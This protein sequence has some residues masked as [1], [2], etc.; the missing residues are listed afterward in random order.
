MKKKLGIALGSGSA[1]GWSHIGVL[2]ALD[3]EGIQ[4]DYISGTSIGSVVGAVYSIGDL[5][6]FEKFT[7]N[8]DWKGVASLID[9]T[10]P[11]SG[12]IPARRLFKMLSEYYK[13]IRI[14]DLPI[15]YCAIA[16]DVRTGE[17]IRFD[18]GKVI[19]AVRASVSIPGILTPHK[20]KGRVLVDGG[21]VNPVP[22]NVVREMGAEVVVAVDL[23]SCTIETGEENRG[24]KGPE[25]KIISESKEEDRDKRILVMLEDKYREF[26]GSIKTKFD[27]L[28]SREHTPNILEIIDNST[29]IMQRSITR[30]QF[31][32]SAP[33]VLIEPQLGDFRLLDFDRADEAIKEGYELTREK[34]GSIKKLL[35]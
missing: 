35:Y 33:D 26:T 3:K 16:A 11:G 27:N 1:R 30:N 2:N 19:D 21:I 7:R 20:Y 23:N 9:V 10:F 18:K 14:Q 31:K 29:H 28:R 34:I 6:T 32:I 15:P 13:D 8:I 4:V 24:K 12:L 22:V 5:E 17:E 25:K